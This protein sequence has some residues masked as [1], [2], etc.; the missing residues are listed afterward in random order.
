MCHDFPPIPL[1]FCLSK[2]LLQDITPDTASYTI[3]IRA[4]G[5]YGGWPAGLYL[6]D[7]MMYRGLSPSTSTIMALMKVCAAQGEYGLTLRLLS[8]LPHPNDTAY[9]TA[10]DACRQAGQWQKARELLKE[11][12]ENGKSERF[13]RVDEL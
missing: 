2:P 13:V 12:E 6:L 10:L 1:H 7:E 3:L 11:M 9:N 8:R 5:G 4:C